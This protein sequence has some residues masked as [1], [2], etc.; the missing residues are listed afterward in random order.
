MIYPHNLKSG[1]KWLGAA[2]SWMQVHRRNSVTW[3]S[4]DIMRPPMTARDMEDF[5]KSVAATAMN[6]ILEKQANALKRS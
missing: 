2:R 4:D 6:E 3:G 5:A 1:G